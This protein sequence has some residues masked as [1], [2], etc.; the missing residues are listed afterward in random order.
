MYLFIQRTRSGWS[1]MAIAQ[2]REAAALQGINVNRISGLTTA[3]GCG[4]AGLAGGLVGS[5]LVLNVPMAD[6]MLVNIIAV[7]VLSGIGSIGGIWV[8]A[9]ILGI[10]HTVTPTYLSGATSEAVGMALIVVILL[11]RPQGLFG[12]EE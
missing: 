11:I 2:D 10:I 4:L 8:G 6:T 5:V 3:I 12:K 9:L 1:M 7:V